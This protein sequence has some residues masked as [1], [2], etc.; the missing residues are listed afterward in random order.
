MGDSTT[1]TSLRLKNTAASERNLP[2]LK[3]LKTDDVYWRLD[4]V[5]TISTRKTVVCDFSTN[6]HRNSMQTSFEA[7]YLQHK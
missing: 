3:S 2:F 7:D 4:S 5:P 1:Q 6:I